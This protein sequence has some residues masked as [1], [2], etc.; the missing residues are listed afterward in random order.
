MKAPLKLNALLA[1]LIG[2]VISQAVVS[3]QDSLANTLLSVTV[4][5]GSAPFAASGSYKL[6]T[7]VIG[8][9]YVVLGRAGAGFSSGTYNYA[10]TGV[11]SG[12]LTL[13]DS[14]SGPGISL[15]LA[16]TSA[17]MGTLALT[18]SAGAQSGAFTVTNYTGAGH[19]DLFLPGFIERK[20]RRSIYRLSTGWNI[21]FSRHPPK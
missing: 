15:A 9:N 2:L 16:F 20:C 21:F 5:S 7:S 14:E 11:N 8:T 6:F 18:G 12:V 1:A 19:P 3:A 13:L 17:T 10:K 4:T